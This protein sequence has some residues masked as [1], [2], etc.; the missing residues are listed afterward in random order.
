MPFL[1]VH[2]TKR[3]DGHVDLGPNA[4]LTFSR[5]DVY[6]ST[7][8]IKDIWNRL[9]SQSFWTLLQRHTLFGLKEL[10]YS[11]NPYAQLHQIQKYLPELTMKDMVQ[12]P[13]GIQAQ[14]LA[15]D[16]TLIDD[17]VFHTTH[18]QSLM[19]VRNAPSPAATSSLAIAEHIADEAETAFQIHL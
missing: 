5:D 4:V 2:L 9:T 7:A 8:N 12:G 19:H 11:W 6:G 10:Y 3:I 17:F 1:G 13:S 18:H 15:E 14:A 16:G